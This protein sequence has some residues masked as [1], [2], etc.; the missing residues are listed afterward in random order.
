MTLDAIDALTDREIHEV[1]FHPRDDKGAIVF[2]RG[3]AHPLPQ[4]VEAPKGTSPDPASQLEA[5][6]AMQAVLGDMVDPTSVEA[7]KAKLAERMK[8]A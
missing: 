8:G 4:P 2:P 7:A 1:Y 5:V 3:T 6:L